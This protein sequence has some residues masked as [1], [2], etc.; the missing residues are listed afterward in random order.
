MVGIKQRQMKHKNWILLGL[1]AVPMVGW[2]WHEYRDA[3]TE[4][5]EVEGLGAVHES[6]NAEQSRGLREMYAMIA[7]DITQAALAEGVPAEQVNA[8]LAPLKHAVSQAAATGRGDVYGE[9]GVSAA[10]IA[11]RMGMPELAKELVARGAEPNRYYV[12]YTA[13]GTPLREDMLCAAIANSPMYGHKTEAM[14]E[15]ESADLLQWLLEHGGDY[16]KCDVETLLRCC[17]ANMMTARSTAKTEQVVR[18]LGSLSPEWQMSV[19]IMMLEVVPDSFPLLEQ[20]FKEG[21]ITREGLEGKASIL[22]PIAACGAEQSPQ[23][24]E[25][26]LRLGLNPNYVPTAPRA[27]DFA[28]VAAYRQAV[29]ECADIPPLQIVLQYIRSASPEGEG[30]ERVERIL[31]CMKILLQAG[32]K[33]ELTPALLPEHA[34]LRAK[35]EAL[36]AEFAPQP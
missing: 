21:I 36:F 23:I 6:W 8:A 18:A 9:N 33:V 10:Y 13:N 7:G 22:T 16:R 4:A 12:T 5:V 32:A 28:S 35:V 27:E 29:A 3:G 17:M 24:L 11:V 26:L 31:L 30:E 34:A 25:R 2:W 1:L 20:W 19:A 14:S 15:A